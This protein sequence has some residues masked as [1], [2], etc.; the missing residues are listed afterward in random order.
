MRRGN[1]AAPAPAC[2]TPKSR[3]RPRQSWKNRHGGDV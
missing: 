1:D 2:R 3:T